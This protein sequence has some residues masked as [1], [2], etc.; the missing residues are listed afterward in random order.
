MVTLKLAIWLLL[1]VESVV[2][3]ERWAQ[4]AVVLVLVV[5]EEALLLLEA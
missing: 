1:L 4:V 3:L 5:Q 2:L